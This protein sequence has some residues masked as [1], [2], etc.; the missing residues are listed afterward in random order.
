MFVSPQNSY[1]GNLTLNVMPLE[2]GAF[3]KWLGHE[4]GALM[5]ELVIL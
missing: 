1:V 5:M 2:G 4:V 3:E